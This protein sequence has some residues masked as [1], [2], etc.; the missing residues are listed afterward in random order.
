MHTYSVGDLDEGVVDG[1]NVDIIT[2]DG[3]TEDNTSN[4]TE[5]VDTNLGLLV[6]TYRSEVL[7][8]H[9]LGAI[10]NSVYGGVA[11]SKR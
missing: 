1:N 7:L 8:S 5:A 6:Q 3:V 10:V 4:T 9:T 11:V 2:V